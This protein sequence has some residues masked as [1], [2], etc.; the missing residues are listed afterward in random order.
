M[1]K[2][3][4][5]QAPSPSS[6]TAS[7]STDSLLS[8][9]KRHCCCCVRLPEGAVLVGL[10]GVSA[11]AGLLVAQ[12]AHGDAAAEWLWAPDALALSSPGGDKSLLAEAAGPATL[13]GH[14]LGIVVNALLGEVQHFRHMS[15]LQFSVLISYAYVVY[16]QVRRW[17]VNFRRSAPVSV[18]CTVLV[19]VIF[20][21]NTYTN[22]Y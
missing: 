19:H 3:G 2:K 4:H 13:V 18:V 12:A 7:S 20:R 22:Y 21:M 6:S 1:K 17:H 8:L 15:Y 9:D 16:V 5:H 14:V 10:Y 11:H